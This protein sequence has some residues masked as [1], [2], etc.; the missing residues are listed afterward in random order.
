MHADRFKNKNKMCVQAIK[1]AYW[2]FTLFWADFHLN[3][4]LPTPALMAL[5][6][7]DKAYHPPVKVYI[8]LVTRR[9]C[10]RQNSENGMEQ[11]V[12]KCACANCQS[13]FFS[14][15]STAQICCELSDP[16]IVCLE[17]HAATFCFLFLQCGV[18]FFCCLWH[19]VASPLLHAIW[20]YTFFISTVSVFIAAVVACRAAAASLP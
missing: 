8:H 4:F 14:Q 11:W 17:S 19:Q 20:I 10:C 9:W 12:K 1:C 16:P 18:K 7:L 13:H 2:I 6:P 3:F 15:F 5:M